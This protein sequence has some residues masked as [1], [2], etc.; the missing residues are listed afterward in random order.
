MA[1]PAP[2]ENF[3]REWFER[4][5]VGL[6]AHN[7]GDVKK[8]A[9]GLFNCRE[10]G[11]TFNSDLVKPG[12]IFSDVNETLWTL[13]AEEQMNVVDTILD[14]KLASAEPPVA[15]QFLCFKLYREFAVL[16]E[17][18]HGEMESAAGFPMAVVSCAQHL[19]DHQYDLTFALEHLLQ[20]REHFLDRLG[21]KKR[22][23][24]AVLIGTLIDFPDISPNIALKYA[25]KLGMEPFEPADV[26]GIEQSHIEQSQMLLYLSLTI[27]ARINTKSN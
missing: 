4:F 6:E 17:S 19:Y 22:W 14:F 26:S 16:E 25:K 21:E 12:I 24:L 10:D 18:G 15:A 2:I 11:G 5:T 7:E 27:H 23:P 1:L 3:A 13:T 8:L 9:K 20:D